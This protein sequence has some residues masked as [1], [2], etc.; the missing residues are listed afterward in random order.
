LFLT[1][2]QADAPRARPQKSRSL[3]ADRKIFG[4]FAPALLEHRCQPGVG[5]DGLGVAEPTHVAQFAEDHLGGHGPHSRRRLEDLPGLGFPLGRLGC[6][7]L[8]L[9]G[10][11][12]A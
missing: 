2:R 10:Q 7:G 8:D 5:A 9:L 4:S 11:S 12:Q 6:E 3:F 1:S